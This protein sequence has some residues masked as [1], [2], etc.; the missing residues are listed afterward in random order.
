MTHD[1]RYYFK[2]FAYEFCHSM[3]VSF[4]MSLIVFSFHYE[5]ANYLEVPIPQGFVPLY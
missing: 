1:L 5:M 2:L 3:S 4:P